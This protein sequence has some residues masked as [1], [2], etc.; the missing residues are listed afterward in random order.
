MALAD[1]V[2]VMNDGRIEQADTP[3]AVFDR[4]TT[5]FVARFIGGHNVLRCTVE[6]LTGRG[7]AARPTRN[8]DRDDRPGLSAGSAVDVAV[9]N[10]R[11]RIGRIEGNC[12]VGNGAAADAQALPSRSCSRRIPGQR[13]QAAPARRTV[14]TS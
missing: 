1:L 5:T 8:S 9:R 12:L 13:R 11:M 2:I 10:D 6:A 3:R 4:P 14:S 7:A